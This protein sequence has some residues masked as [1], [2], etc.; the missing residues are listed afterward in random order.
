MEEEW[1]EQEE[2]KTFEKTSQIVWDSTG[3]QERVV[4]GTNQKE[5]S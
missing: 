1:K 5:G 4:G 3:K 2:V